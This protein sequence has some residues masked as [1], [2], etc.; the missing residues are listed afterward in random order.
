MMEE[1]GA[2]N[3]PCLGPNLVSLLSLLSFSASSSAL[4]IAHI[5]VWSTSRVSAAVGLQ[6]EPTL[7]GSYLGSSSCSFPPWLGTY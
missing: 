6:C 3:F 7:D 5:R 1:G 4:Y 2:Q